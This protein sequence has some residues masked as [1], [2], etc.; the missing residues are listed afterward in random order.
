M[1]NCQHYFKFCLTISKIIIDVAT[2]ALSDSA[3]PG[4]GIIKVSSL[5]L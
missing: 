3:F 5:I 4:I 2:A 1:C